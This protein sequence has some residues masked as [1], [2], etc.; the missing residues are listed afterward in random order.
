MKSDRVEYVQSSILLLPNAQPLYH[1]QNEAYQ[2]SHGQRFSL[3]E[4]CSTNVAAQQL[5]Y[6]LQ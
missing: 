4:E 3:L 6:L 5:Y 1:S 2:L